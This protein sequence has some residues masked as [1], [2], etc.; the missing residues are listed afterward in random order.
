MKEISKIIIGELRAQM[1]I[2]KSICK[3]SSTFII[4]FLKVES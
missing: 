1:H 3:G 2:G 4:K